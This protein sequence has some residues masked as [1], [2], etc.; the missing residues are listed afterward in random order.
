MEK[1]QF[2][3]RFVNEETFVQLMHKSY[4]WPPSPHSE[5]ENCKKKCTIFALPLFT[6]DKSSLRNLLD[7]R[8]GNDDSV[9]DHD[10]HG[11]QFLLQRTSPDGSPSLGSQVGFSQHN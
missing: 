5:L 6:E 1:M 8:D 7:L 10:G 3:H 9:G 2:G 11:S 4:P